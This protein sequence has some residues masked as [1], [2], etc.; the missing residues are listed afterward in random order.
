METEIVRRFNPHW[1]TQGWPQTPK[2]RR[3]LFPKLWQHLINLKLMVYLIGARRMG[4]SVLLRQIVENLLIAKQIPP[5]QI[6]WYE[7]SQNSQ[8]S[9]IRQVFDYF[10]KEVA[11]NGQLAYVFFDEIQFARGYEVEMKLL[12]DQY[13][14]R[15]KFLMTGSLSLTYKRKV[16]ESMAG[17]FLP[18]RLYPLF[19]EEYLEM[20]EDKSGLKIYKDTTDIVDPRLNESFREFLRFG[21]F[22]EVLDKPLDSVG[23]YLETLGN[24]VLNQDAFAYFDVRRPN[25]LVKLYEYLRINSGGELSISSLAKTASFETISGYLDILEIMGIVYFVYNKN[26]S[27]KAYV[28]SAIYL[29]SAKHDLFSA[30]GFAVESY[31]YERLMQKGL[32]VNFWRKRNREVDFVVDSPRQAFEVKFRSKVDNL[33]PL[34][35]FANRE[36]YDPVVVSFDQIGTKAGITYIPACLF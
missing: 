12:Y 29:Q 24:L 14:G 11:N 19:F 5:R 23:L 8:T 33:K 15:V 22:P 25:E 7:F 4:K 32:K 26:S 30:Y 2:F 20:K 21:R 35:E 3:Y 27:R 36:R 34:I 31:V 6:L 17:R 16:Q 9:E 28:N 10:Y 13:E 18:Y 1:S